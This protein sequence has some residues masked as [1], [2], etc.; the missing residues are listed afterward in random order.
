[1]LNINSTKLINEVKMEA[2]TE[3]LKN[4]KAGLKL[5]ENDT[6]CYSEARKLPVHLLSLV[7][8]KLRKLTEKDLLELVPPRGNKWASPIVV[9]R[10]SDGD[11]RLCGEYEIGINHKV[12]SDS[13]PI[14][15]VGVSFHALAGMS[16]FTR[17]D[18]KT[19]YHQILID[20]NFKEVTTINTPIGLLK[21]K[22]M[23]Y[24]IKTAKTIFQ[25]AV[26]QVLGE[27]I[28]KYDLSPRHRSY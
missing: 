2:K 4:Y 23:P 14:P 12:C 26:E 9:L 21:W 18:F 6:P 19:A 1:M 7:V 10:K 15:N 3:K 20:N 24:G 27:D 25:R 16:V 22:R 5:K 8:A 11:R 17:I 13:Y 28:K